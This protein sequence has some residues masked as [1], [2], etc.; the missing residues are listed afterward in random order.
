MFCKRL[1]EIV[2][3]PPAAFLWLLLLGTALRRRWPRF[4]RALQPYPPLPATGT[5]PAADAIVVLSA[6]GERDARE[7]GGPSVGSMTLQRIRY[8]AFLH[9]RTHLPILTSGGRPGSEREPL[10]T[11]MARVLEQ[12]FGA[13][14]RWQEDRS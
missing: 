5:L 7:Y 13:E 10:A 4:G 2:L 6:E 9:H 1:L 12:E 3:L 8:A 11:S 14:V